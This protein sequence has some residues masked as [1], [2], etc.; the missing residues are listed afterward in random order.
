[1]MN[2]KAAVA[3]IDFIE[4]AIFSEKSEEHKIWLKDL[5]ARFKEFSKK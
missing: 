2:E 3:E 1:M 5:L 4:R